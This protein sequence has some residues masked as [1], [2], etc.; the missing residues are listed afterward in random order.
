MKRYI[1]SA[2]ELAYNNKLGTTPWSA[3]E[4]ARTQECSKRIYDM[5]EDLGWDDTEEDGDAVE[6]YTFDIPSRKQTDVT[7]SKSY[8]EKVSYDRNGEKY[9]RI[10]NT[11]FYTVDDYGMII[12]ENVIG[13]ATLPDA[14]HAA[15]IYIKEEIDKYSR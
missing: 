8:L 10:P 12:D 11:T 3:D 2:K 5:R 4:E 7:I 13:Y 9:T 6:V 14:R 15:M 1:K